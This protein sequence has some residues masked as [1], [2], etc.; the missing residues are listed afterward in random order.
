MIMDYISLAYNNFSHKRLRSYLTLLGILIGVTAVVGLIGL[1]EGLRMAI[2]SQFGISSTEV[3]TVQAGG[4]TG[5]GPPGTGVVNPLKFDDVEDIKKLGTVKRA[6]PRW[7]QTGKLEF[8]DRVGFGVATTVPDGDDRKFMYDMLEVDPEVGRFLKDGDVNKIMLG[9][10]FYADK[11][12]YGKI[13]QPGDTVLIQDKKFEVVGIVEKKGSFILDNAVYM[14]Q[15]P[16]LDLFDIDTDVDLIGVQVKDKSLMKKTKEDIEKI[17]RKNRDV[18]VGEEDFSVE[19]PESALSDVNDVLIGVQIFIVIIASISILVGAIGITNTMFTSVIE[20][21]K[22]IGIMKSIGARNKDIFFIF[23]V[24]SGMMGL[25]GGFIGIVF[26][27][28]ISYIGTI[29][30]NAW[31]NSTS[32]PQINFALIGGA[33]FGSFLIGAVSGI[34]PAMNAASENPV[35]ALR[36]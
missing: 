30:I 14:N 4:I 21:R 33:L 5:G 31:I 11:S 28:L 16:L 27:T 25:F 13:I 15:K 29:G 26:G 19:T 6:V 10:N 22:Q 1:G 35:D 8:N 34:V 9:Y 20:R 36:G 17:L 18:K 23:F 24:E 12:M 7:I 32:A 3:L 2:T